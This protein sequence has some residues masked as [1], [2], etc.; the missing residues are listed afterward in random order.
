MTT[1]NPKLF[2]YAV[3]PFCKKVEAILK[4]K[5]IPYDAVEVHPLNKKEIKFSE[6]YR[7]VPIYLDEDGNQ[8]NDSTPIMK[9][10]DGKHASITVF[11]D[12]PNEQK[13]VKWSDETLVRALPPLIY[14]TLPS[15]LKAFNYITKEGKFSFFQRA[16]IKYSGALVMMMVAKKKAKKNNIPD[17]ALHFENCLNEWSEALGSHPY[18]GGQN[19]NGADMAVFGILRSVHQLP[20]KKYME[21]N[22]KVIDWY[23]KMETLV[24]N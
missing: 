19:P 10:I 9:H 12:S 18:I 21:D 14:K 23:K 11:D 13:W 6:D 4:Y 7:K 5:K 20:A 15:S 16:L 22:Q 8:I 24:Y 1:T 2:Q 3:C 17:P